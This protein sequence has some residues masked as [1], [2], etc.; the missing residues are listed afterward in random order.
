MKRKLKVALASVCVVAVGFGGMK[1][2]N[3]YDNQLASNLLSENVEALSNGEAGWPILFPSGLYISMK[4]EE[5]YNRKD[6]I[7]E[8]H[9]K[10]ITKTSSTSPS[11]KSTTSVSAGGVT[12][13]QTNEYSLC[14]NTTT[15]KWT[16]YCNGCKRVQDGKGNYAHCYDIPNRC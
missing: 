1:T 2:Y 8:P 6:Y 15:E 3:H 12:V 9:K 16:E 13:S 7:A 10:E 4:F 5:Y 14:S 11:I